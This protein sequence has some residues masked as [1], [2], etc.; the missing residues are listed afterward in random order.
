MGPAIARWITTTHQVFN[1]VLSADTF[2]ENDD[3]NHHDVS[4]PGYVS[5][6]K[7]TSKKLIQAQELAL[8]KNTLDIPL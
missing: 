6:L 8:L 3:P 2:V 7:V 1:A 5:F 4:T